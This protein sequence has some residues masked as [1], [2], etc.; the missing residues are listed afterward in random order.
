MRAHFKCTRLVSNETLDIVRP[1]QRVTEYRAL[2]NYS[3]ARDAGGW[4]RDS[5]EIC[6]EAWGCIS[7]DRD[8]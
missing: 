7:T 3:A 4:I 5:W 6:N 2:E 8:R 1:G